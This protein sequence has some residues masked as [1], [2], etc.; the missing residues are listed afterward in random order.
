MSR[1]RAVEMI[2]RPLGEMRMHTVRRSFGFSVRSNNPLFTILSTMMEAAE[3]CM[4]M[5]SANFLSDKPWGW[6]SMSSMI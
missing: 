6:L 5:E 3:G 4:D 1:V 2:S